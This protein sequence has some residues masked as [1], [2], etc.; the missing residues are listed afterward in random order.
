M[1]VTTEGKMYVDLLDTDGEVT[2][3]K[4]LAAFSYNH[5]QRQ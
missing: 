4:V 3:A 2:K 5:D 1:R